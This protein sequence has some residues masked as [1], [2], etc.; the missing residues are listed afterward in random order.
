MHEEKQSTLFSYVAI[1]F[2]YYLLIFLAQLASVSRR[3][4]SRFQ[5]LL[6]PRRRRPVSTCL[7]RRCGEGFKGITV[8]KNR[9]SGTSFTYSCYIYPHIYMLRALIEQIYLQFH[10][11]YGQ[12]EKTNP[13]GT[14]KFILLLSLRDLLLSLHNFFISYFQTIQ[15][16]TTLFCILDLT[17]WNLMP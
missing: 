11:E 17:A 10:A 6:V 4:C 9:T 14:C 12:N 8:Y 2:S 3:R 16:Y 1:N 5:M 13:T 15:T 7:C